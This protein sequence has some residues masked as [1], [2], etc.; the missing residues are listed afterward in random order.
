MIIT[1]QKASFDKFTSNFPSRNEAELLLQKGS[2]ENPGPW[3]NHCKLTAKVAETIAQKCGLDVDRAYVSGL[4]H[5]IGYSEFRDYKGRTCHI[6]IGSENMLAKGF[7]AIARICLSHSF[8]YKDIAAYGGKDTNWNNEE[9]ES[10][11]RF[12][13]ETEFDNYDKLI[14]LCDVLAAADGI[15]LMEKRMVDV[16]RRHG[17]GEFT[18]Q[19]WDATFNLKNYF[20]N[21][22]GE[23]IYNF[24]AS[25]IVSGI[26]S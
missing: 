8:P 10:I 17:F 22:C 25:E 15:C 6:I 24:F 7:D 2:I 19:K 13:S 16:V 9:K 21:L 1:M 14:Q 5:D 11:M 3:V 26:L 18:M 20:D 12:L 23:N 4:L